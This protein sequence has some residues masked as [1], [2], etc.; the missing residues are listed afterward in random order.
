MMLN[1]EYIQHNPFAEQGR[2]FAIEVLTGG[3][4]SGIVSTNLTFFVGNGYG[5]MHYKSLTL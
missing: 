2:E 3:V 4:A 5:F 1:R